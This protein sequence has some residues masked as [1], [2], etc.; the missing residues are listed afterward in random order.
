MADNTTLNAGTG[1]DVI[2]TD[3]I[4]GVKHQLVKIEFGAADSATQASSANPFPV[5]QTGTPG[6]PTGASTA[7]KQP[8]L[9][10]AGSASADV[11]SIQ[12]VASM[13]AV[14]V[15][16]S[17][18][19]QPVSGPL[20]D[21]QLRASA[22]PVSL[23]SAPSTPVTNAG[24]FAVQADTELT[25]ADLDSGA[26]TDTRA[27]VGLVIA[28]SG[29]AAN[30]SASD[31]LPVVQSGTSNVQI[32]GGGVLKAEDVAA[33]SGD[34]G[35]PMLGV[36][37]DTAGTLTSTDGDYGHVALDSSGRIGVSD[38]GGSLTVDGTVTPATATQRVVI[39]TDQFAVQLT[40]ALKVDGGAPVTQ[41]VSGTVTANLG[42]VRFGR[43]GPVEVP[44]RVR[45][46]DERDERES[47]RGE[48]ARLVHLQLQRRRPEGRVPQHGGHPD[49]GRVGDG[50]D[51]DPAD[52]RGE[53]V[54]GHRDRVQ[55]RGSRSRP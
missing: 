2:A 36:R 53:R 16:G 17:A 35:F 37:N 32:Q 39:A 42:R 41:P 30:I 29:G 14:K 52:E 45:G 47:V 19:T 46:D 25:T 43:R 21:T 13:T 34:T 22:V 6:L 28:K 33:S 18:V 49:R 5:V 50:R 8:A 27:V 40:N 51:R 48:A 11:L 20:T 10:T 26:G 15:D 54:H 4:S 24:T 3:D 12:G 44:S 31:P 55:R 38:L 7:A 23:A 1:G 9:G